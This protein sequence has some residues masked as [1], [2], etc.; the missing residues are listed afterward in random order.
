MRHNN[1]IYILSSVALI[2]SACSKVVPD[3]VATRSIIGFNTVSTST[4]AVTSKYP[5]DKPFRSTAFVYS[6]SWDTDKASSTKYIDDALVK[7]NSEYTYWIN[8]KEDGSTEDPKPWP[9]GTSKLTFFSYSPSSLKGKVSV[10]TDGV[11]ISSWNVEIDSGDILVADIAK[12]K[13]KNESLAGYTG[14]PTNFRQKL[15]KIVFRFRIADEAVEGTQVKVT[16][17]SLK[18]VYSAGSYSRG[19]YEDDKWTTSS[20]SFKSSGWSRYSGTLDIEKGS[21]S[22]EKEFNMIPQR[23]VASASAH[24]ILE[25]GYELSTDYGSNWE[26]KTASCYF[27]ENLRQEE[28]EK[29]KKYTYSIYIG[30]GQYPIEFDATVLDWGLSDQGTI[31][32]G[33]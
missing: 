33:G 7:Y 22:A 15:S 30:V 21:F 2:V 29:G 16:S 32:I 10:S 3:E 13:T 25:I 19:G 4:K 17:I 9:G 11:G 12:D 14:V 5:T 23:L 8:Y 26:S 20:T 28:W 27:D 6:G 31:N 1:I 24:P 18:D